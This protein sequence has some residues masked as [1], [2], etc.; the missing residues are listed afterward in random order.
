MSDGDQR[1]LPIKLDATSG[2][3]FAPVPADAGARQKRLAAERIAD[4][5][6]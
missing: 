3:A 2:G 1:H 4:N 5:A 6:R